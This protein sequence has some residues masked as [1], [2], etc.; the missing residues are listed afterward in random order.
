MEP[1]K[2]RESRQAINRVY[3]DI[4]TLIE[5]KDLEAS[6]ERHQEVTSKLEILTP[7]AE[8]EIQER[9]VKNLR[10]KINALNT[11]IGKLKPKKTS[12]RGRKKAAKTAI[13]WDEERVGQLSPVFLKKVLS[14]MG[15]DTNAKVY[16][17]TTGKGIRPSYQIEFG[18]EETTTFSGSGHKPVKKSLSTATKEAAQSFAYPLIDSILNGK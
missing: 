4:I 11:P 14:N 8:G 16:F 13:V 7:Q 1:N 12:V 9:S 3:D 2:F 17:G 18:N 5:N 6:K 15:D 10:L